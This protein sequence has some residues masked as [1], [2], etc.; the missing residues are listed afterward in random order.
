MSSKGKSN[1]HSKVIQQLTARPAAGS[2]EPLSAASLKSKENHVSIA[3]VER[4]GNARR[5]CLNWLALQTS[6]IMG[7]DPE[8]D[9][10]AEASWKAR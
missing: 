4:I 3:V 9:S 10:D 7:K 1:S 5:V 6:S 2:A 8:V